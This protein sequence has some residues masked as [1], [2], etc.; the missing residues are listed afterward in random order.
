M[1]SL[2]GGPNEMTTYNG[3]AAAA[4]GDLFLK[5][6]ASSGGRGMSCPECW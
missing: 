5:G 4:N 1:V 2:V 6:W 3:I